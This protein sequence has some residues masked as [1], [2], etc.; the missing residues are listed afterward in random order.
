MLLYLSI[1]Y[2]SFFVFVYILY[3]LSTVFL[4]VL[5]NSTITDQLATAGASSAATTTL[6]G[7]NVPLYKLIFL[8]AVLI[9]G[10][11]SGLVAGMMGEGNVYSGL[12]H[13]AIMVAIGYVIFILFI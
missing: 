10:L 8:H 4:P 13:S 9:Q 7:I 1:I 5:P 11:F 6:G 12:K 3:T 2:I